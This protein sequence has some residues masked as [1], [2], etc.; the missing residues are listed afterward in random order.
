MFTAGCVLIIAGL[1][2]DTFFPINKK[3]WSTSYV[4]FSGGWAMAILAGCYYL[5]DMKQRKAWSFPFV[6]LG[7]NAILVYYLSTLMAIMMSRITVG[8]EGTALKTW[9]Y[10]K[11]FVS[12]IEPDKL[13]SLT[14]ALSYVVLWVILT[15][16]LYRKKIFLKI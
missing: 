6:I 3:N 4:F 2:M 11:Y 8:E 13:A 1:C 9:L 5:L 10:R 7:T 16:P 15:Y 12:S 14:W